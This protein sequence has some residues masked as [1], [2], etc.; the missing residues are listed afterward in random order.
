[1]SQGQHEGFDFKSY[2]PINLIRRMSPIVKNGVGAAMFLHKNLEKEYDAIIVATGL[3]CVKDSVKF[4]DQYKDKEEGLVAPTSFIQSTHNTIA[5]QIALLLSNHCYN[6]TFV[7]NGHSFETALVDAICKTSENSN[8]LFGAADEF[9][10]ILPEFA[11]LFDLDSSLISEG[12]T[13][14][15]L[16]ESEGKIGIDFGGFFECDSFNW[17]QIPENVLVFY[18][19]SDLIKSSIDDNPRIDIRYDEYCG[20]FMTNSAFAVHLA[21]DIL[22]NGN[23]LTNHKQF[24]EIWILNNYQ[25]RKFG[26]MKMT[27]L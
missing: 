2:V 6:M 13:F 27:S 5:G 3:G 16:S 17:N 10:D 19:R 25:D 15:N 26:L 1:M 14:M 12:V 22:S 18:G 8:V 4:I 9:H 11:D 21:Y 20:R 24:P 23:K 7:Q